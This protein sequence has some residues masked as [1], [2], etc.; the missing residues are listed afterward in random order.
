M[1][2]G[3]LNKL[4][5]SSGDSTYLV[6]HII[7]DKGEM[8]SGEMPLRNVTIQDNTKTYDATILKVLRT[9]SLMLVMVGMLITL[10][11]ALLFLMLVHL[12]R[13]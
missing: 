1:N 6:E 3:F 11:K 12:P 8:E 10:C 7:D 5:A 9:V 2:K 4:H 13:M